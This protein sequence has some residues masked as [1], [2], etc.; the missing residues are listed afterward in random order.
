MAKTWSAQV[1]SLAGGVFESVRV[2]GGARAQE[3][4]NSRRYAAEIAIGTSA[5][6]KHFEFICKWSGGA[7]GRARRT[8]SESI[9][10]GM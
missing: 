7:G 5:P 3:Q 10:F 6:R 4:R 2:A 9:S 1:I 8:R